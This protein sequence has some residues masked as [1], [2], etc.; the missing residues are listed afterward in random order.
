MRSVRER[1][2]PFSITGGTEWMPKVVLHQVA[3]ASRERSQRPTRTGMKVPGPAHCAL[4]TRWGAKR[5][6]VRNTCCAITLLL[7]WLTSEM[8]SESGSERAS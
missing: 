4:R 8:M 6:S 5:P 7:Q 3:T 2:E 1:P